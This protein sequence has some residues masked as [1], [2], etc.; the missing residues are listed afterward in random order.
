MSKLKQQQQKKTA[1][2][3]KVLLCSGLDIGTCTQE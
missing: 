3:L 2:N 1:R